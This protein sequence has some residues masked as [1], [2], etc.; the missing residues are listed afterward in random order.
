MRRRINAVRQAA[1]DHKSLPDKRFRQLSRNTQAIR[2]HAPRAHDGQ[3]AFRSMTDR[4]PS[5]HPQKHGGIVYLTQQERVIRIPQGNHLGAGFFGPGKLLLYSL[6]VIGSRDLHRNIRTNTGD[7]SQRCYRSAKYG[8]GRT[9]ARH[10]HAHTPRPDSRNQRKRN[11][12]SSLRIIRHTRRG[13][14]A[15]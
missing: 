2:R 6:P 10:K 4:Q 7:R 15:R 3:H 11:E 9:H 13:E 14:V 5:P 1:D 8:P 12:R